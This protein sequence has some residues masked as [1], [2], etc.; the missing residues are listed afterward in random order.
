MRLSPT[1]IG[2]PAF[3]APFGVACRR[4]AREEISA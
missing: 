3:A 1:T 2:K 4:I